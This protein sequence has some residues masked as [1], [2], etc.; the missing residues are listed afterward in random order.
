MDNNAANRTLS[1]DET[2]ISSAPRRI[3]R[4]AAILDAA[5]GGRQGPLLEFYRFH[6]AVLIGRY[7]RAETE[8]RRD[9]CIRHGI[10]QARR[11]TG[12]EALYVDEGQ[13]AWSLFIAAH[14]GNFALSNALAGVCRGVV[15]GLGRLGVEAA[16]APPNTVEVSGRR[17]AACHAV[18]AKSAT[19]VQG[20]LNATLDVGRMLH[21]L[22]IPREKL[23][24]QGLA[25]ARQ[26]FVALDDLPGIGPTY[27]TLRDALCS[28][29]AESFGFRA[30][31]GERLDLHA[32]N[33]GVTLP[34]WPEDRADGFAEA[35]WPC[36]GGWVLRSRLRIAGSPRR[37]AFFELAGDVMVDPPDLFDRIADRLRGAGPAS[38]RARLAALF[39]ALDIE[40]IGCT[41]RD[42]ADAVSRALDRDAQRQAFGLDMEEANCLVIHNPENLDAAEIVR[43]ASVI[44]VPY[45][46]KAV[47]CKWRQRDGCSECG[48]CEVGEAYHIARERGMQAITITNYEHL[49]ETLATLKR[50][51]VAAYLGMCCS[52]FY[53]KRNRAFAEAGVPA[54][55]MDIGGANCYE[56]HQ[57][58]QA[59]AGG[60]EAKAELGV[61]LLDKVTSVKRA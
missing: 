14:S 53:L 21:A 56:L 29:L 2:G 16:F 37:I 17:I 23:S 46:A 19:L 8:V 1:I 51:G 58:E 47:G 45:C 27:E 28:G 4:D 44:L 36:A 50:E 31:A 20:T 3:A 18:R 40:L 9:Y 49:V 12:G 48:L 32:M 7:Q 39:A 33:L 10:E 38:W 35:V 60:F 13:I 34:E 42:I 26:R 54:V 59:Y 61:P 6:P 57:E 5:S 22:R 24:P 43:R 30:A 52:Q 55:L 25:G 41:P 15:A 11:L